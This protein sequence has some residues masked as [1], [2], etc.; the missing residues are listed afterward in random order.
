MTN[1]T[2]DMVLDGD[3]YHDPRKIDLQYMRFRVSKFQ[4]VVRT[5]RFDVNTLF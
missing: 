1:N 3:F 4:S 2:T 5:Y